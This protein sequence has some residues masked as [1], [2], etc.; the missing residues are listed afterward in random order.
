MIINGRS[1]L[2][3]AELAQRLGVSIRTLV[4]WHK[5]GIGPRRM[6]IGNFIIYAEDEVIPTIKRTGK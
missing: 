2:K 3:E 6:K 1:Y 5:Q 4:R